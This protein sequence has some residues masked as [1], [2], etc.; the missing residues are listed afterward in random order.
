MKVLWVSDYGL[1]HHQG[2]AQRSNSLI[3]EE[4]K[5]RGH[6]V[7]E[8]NVDS[9]DRLLHP[10]YDLLV[11][12]NLEALCQ[13]PRLVEWTSTF[14]NH[15]RVEHDSNRYLSAE[16]R[17][18]LFSS[19]KKSFFLSNFHLQQFISSYGDYFTNAEIIP[20]PI[21]TNMFCDKKLKREDKTLYVGFMHELKGTNEFFAHVI[22]NPEDSFV[23]AG[24]SND[25]RFTQTCEMLSNVEFLGKVDFSEMPILYNKHRSLFYK[26]TFY[27]PYCRSVAEAIFCGMEVIGNDLIGCLHHMKEAGKDEMVS[28]CSRAPESFWESVEC[29]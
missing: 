1:H 23:V 9:D 15:V 19:C 16:D 26:P 22:E 11:S 20:D 4:G 25:P 29:L 17:K 13:K 7:I 3:I 28:Q 12:S 5:K 18:L 2:G 14:P 8:F 10:E 21:D 24:W 27:E 6:S